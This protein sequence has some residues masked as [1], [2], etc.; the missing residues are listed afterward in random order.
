MIWKMGVVVVATWLFV[1]GFALGNPTA[2]MV[3]MVVSAVLSVGLAVAAVRYPRA[4]YGVVAIG[5]WLVLSAWLLPAPDRTFWNNVACG[6]AL[7]VL[8]LVSR[9]YRPTP[10]LGPD[11]HAPLIRRRR[12]A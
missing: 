12:H 10:E 6:V 2:Q 8:S 11:K 4:I 3:N 5:G 1:A 9:P 7:S